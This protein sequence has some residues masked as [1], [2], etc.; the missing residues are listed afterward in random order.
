MTTVKLVSY[1]TPVERLQM[2]G[3]QTPSDLV[4]YCARVSNPN[5]QFNT[6]TADRL[7]KFLIK[8]KHWSPLEMVDAT[9]EIEAS[10]AVSRQ[11]IRHRS[12]VF[13]EF[14]QRYA[15]VQGFTFVPC[16]MQDPDNRQSSLPSEDYELDMEWRRRQAE[17]SRVASEAY[18]WALEQG[19]AKELAR[20]VLP[21]GLTD[22]TL[23]M[24]GSLRSWIHYCELRCGNGTQLEHQVLAI[25]IARIIAQLFPVHF[26]ENE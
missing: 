9:F 19:I 22:S 26:E 5:N 16:R 6:E 20:S 12:F 2:E 11:I 4:A 13:Q 7:L 3:I 15:K 1:T 17:V 21:E 14:S 8:H 24:K 23:Y 25:Q 18:H 10:R